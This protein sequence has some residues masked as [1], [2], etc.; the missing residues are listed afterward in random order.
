MQAGDARARDIYETLGVYLGYALA[1]LASVYDFRYVLVLGRVMSGP[2][3]D[4][5]LD[6]ARQVLGADFPA[7]ASRI[8]LRMPG[9]LDRRHGQ[10]IAAAS[11]PDRAAT[12]GS[13]VGS[14]MRAY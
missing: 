3:G 11:L 4:I 10:A 7:L 13:G 8:D 1:Q 12:A 9:E 14:A 5:M 2:G 6:K